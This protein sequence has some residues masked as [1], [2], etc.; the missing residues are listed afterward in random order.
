MTD[1]LRDVWQLW[2]AIIVGLLSGYILNRY[3]ERSRSVRSKILLYATVGSVALAVSPA[4]INSVGNALEDDTGPVHLKVDVQV[5]ASGTSTW[6]RETWARPGDVVEYLIRVENMGP[7]TASDIAVGFN[8]APNQIFVANSL[9]LRNSNYPN[10]TEIL[11]QRG[12]SGGQHLLY[13]GL[14]IGNAQPGG[15]SY[16]YWQMR[17]DSKFKTDGM[18]AMRSYGVAHAKGNRS[19]PYQNFVVVNVEQ[20]Q[21]P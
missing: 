20:S 8:S 3:E 18:Y 5:R 7:S 19:L 2:V 12:K 14:D 16:L 13:G 1:W 21:P 10:G 17:I 9:K 15:V 11:D 6:S 4:L